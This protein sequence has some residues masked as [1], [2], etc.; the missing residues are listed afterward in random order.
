[1]DS[2]S[3]SCRSIAPFPRSILVLG[4]SRPAGRKY[5]FLISSDKVKSEKSIS[6]EATKTL[7]AQPLRAPKKKNKK[8]AATESSA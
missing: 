6:D 3:S 8:A 4:V 7:I 5:T 2:G 1:M